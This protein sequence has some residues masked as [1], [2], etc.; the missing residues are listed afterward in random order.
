MIDC[1]N[2][3]K[4][5]FSMADVKNVRSI[6]FAL[7]GECKYCG[8][9]QSVASLWRRTKTEKWKEVPVEKKKRKV[10]DSVEE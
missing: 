9:L 1:V 3:N 7:K 2:C 4:K 10:N 6:G 5:L 8:T